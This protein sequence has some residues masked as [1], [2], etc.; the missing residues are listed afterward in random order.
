MCRLFAIS[1]VA[2]T[3]ILLTVTGLGAQS[4][5]PAISGRVID[6]DGAVVAGAVLRLWQQSLGFE[7]VVKT[8]DSGEFQFKQLLKGK[9][10]FSVTG[11]G[12]AALTR[13][14]DLAGDEN[15]KLELVL[16]PAAIAEEMAVNGPRIADTP[17]I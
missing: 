14:I 15:A 8:D 16:E 1:T 7:R 2:T 9:Y 12:F 10:Q 13:E 4:A 11:E 17:E 3:L 6:K 5:A